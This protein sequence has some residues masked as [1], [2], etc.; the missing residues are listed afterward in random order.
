[1]PENKEI[2]NNATENI[3]QNELESDKIQIKNRRKYCKDKTRYK[4]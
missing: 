1:M 2:K 4:K 3:K